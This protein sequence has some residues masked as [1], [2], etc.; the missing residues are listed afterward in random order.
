LLA[1]SPRPARPW[2]AALLS[3]AFP[4]LGHLYVWQLQAAAIAW[5]C[6]AAAG[7]LVVLAFVA[8]PHVLLLLLAIA[9]FVLT[10]G[11]VIVHAW[12]N[13][14]AS[15]G[16]NRPS[17]LMLL[18]LLGA[19]WMGSSYVSTSLQGWLRRNVMVAYR[20]PANSMEPTIVIGD[21]IVVDPRIRRPLEH[22]E[23]VA[24][25]V[26][27]GSHLKRAVGLAGDTLSMRDGQLHRNGVA[28]EEPYAINLDS[29]GNPALATW[30]PVVVPEARLFV[31][32]D[33]RNNSFDSRQLGFID[34]HNVLG[35]PL[36]IYFSRDPE[37]GDVRWRR[38][39]RRF[40]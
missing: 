4:G 2:L 28:V 33:N 20:I 15:G 1:S 27:T 19:F 40:E 12:R 24:Y 26:A 8:A 37:T 35:R 22:D 17:R 36:R 9:A 34:E 5:V 13:A 16:V 18:A 21:F 25:R 31:L 11:A 10:Y 39:G 30:G 3:L 6:A 23:I 7:A 14:R 38:I 32:G 29:L